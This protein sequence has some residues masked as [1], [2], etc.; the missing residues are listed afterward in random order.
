M[1]IVNPTGDTTIKVIPRQSYNYISVTYRNVSTDETLVSDN[2]QP[3][4]TDNGISFVFTNN[5]KELL[6]VAEGQFVNFELVGAD[7]ESESQSK[8]IY[9]GRIFITSQTIS[10]KSNQVYD[11][12]ENVYKEK[13]PSDNEYIIF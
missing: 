11:I 3:V 8:F 9:R 13:L 7:T 6:K 12:N 1:E 5:E 10:Q 2:K 4:I